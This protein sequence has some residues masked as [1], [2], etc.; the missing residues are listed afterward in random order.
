[1]IKYCEGRE[2]MKK[3]EGIVVIFDF[4]GTS[5]LATNEECNEFIKKTKKIIKMIEMQKKMWFQ[6]SRGSVIKKN[7]PQMEIEIFQDTI[8]LI[9]PLSTNHPN[10][11]LIMASL[12]CDVFILGLKN[13]ILLRGAI[14]YGEIYISE[15]KGRKIYLGP[16]IVDAAEW[17]SKSEWAG[18]IATPK[19]SYYLE[20]NAA[21][22]KSR[23]FKKQHKEWKDLDSYLLG[24]M[25]WSFCKYVV[26]MKNTN[27]EIWV[28]C[29]PF[30]L[31]L[32]TETYGRERPEGILKSM[33]LKR[34]AWFYKL[35]SS[36][37]PIKETE[38]IKFENTTKFMTWYIE[39]LIDKVAI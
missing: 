37:K 28:V 31:L 12:I 22:E 6:P 2:E 25:H 30:R 7:N 4:L 27:K 5:S 34:M 33:R 15:I 39:N 10:L 8:M 11:M 24:H 18:V 35:M 20:C 14:S 3:K 19:T 29:W 21:S 36:F 1:M 13:Q 23:I 26:P 17:Y 32:D 16:A 38:L 9:W